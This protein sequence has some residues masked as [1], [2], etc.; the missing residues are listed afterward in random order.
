MLV[1]VSR[2][3]VGEA[4]GYV[5]LWRHAVQMQAIRILTKNTGMPSGAMTRQCDCYLF[6]ISLRDLIRAIELIRRALPAASESLAAALTDFEQQVPNAVQLRDVLE[7]FDDYST[8]QGRLQREHPGTMT[9]EWYAASDDS[10][11]LN[12]SVAPGKFFTLEVRAASRAATTLA[13]AVK[14]ISYQHLE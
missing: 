11:E 12:I 10:Y 1:T 2:A 9:S 5:D 4:I 6:V 13:N 8:G 14:E 7:H 3:A